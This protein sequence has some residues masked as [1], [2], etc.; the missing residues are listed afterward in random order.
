MREAL[1]STRID[2]C[3]EC[4]HLRKGRLRDYCD[5]KDIWIPDSYFKRDIPEWCPYLLNPI[6]PSG[7]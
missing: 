1:V 2:S 3:D 5:P 4:P 7:D 6:V